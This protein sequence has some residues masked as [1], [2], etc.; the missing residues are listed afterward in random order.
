MLEGHKLMNKKDSNNSVQKKCQNA[1]NQDRKSSGGYFELY[2]DSE[3][4]SKR[5]DDV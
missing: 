1:A 3:S 2:T 5:S 4:V